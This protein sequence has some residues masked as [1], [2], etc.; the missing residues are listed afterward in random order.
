MSRLSMVLILAVLSGCGASRTAPASSPSAGRKLP[1]TIDLPSDCRQRS[2]AGVDSWPGEWSCPAFLI[3]YDWGARNLVGETA[4]V[5]AGMVADSAWTETID[6]RKVELI[7]YAAPVDV[8]GL[9]A[10]WADAGE[11]RVGGATY[12]AALRLTAEARGSAALGGALTLVRSI[13]WVEQP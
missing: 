12:P 3:R 4:G 13:R 6:G 10:V 9:V 1:F 11:L 7:H 5:P 2:Y 8:L